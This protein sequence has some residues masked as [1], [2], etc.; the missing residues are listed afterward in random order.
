MVAGMYRVS[1]GDR[2]RTQRPRDAYRLEFVVRAAHDARSN[3]LFKHWRKTDSMLDALC[4]D[5]IYFIF[6]NDTCQSVISSQPL[7]VGNR[8]S[9]SANTEMQ[10]R[11][12]CSP[13]FE[14]TSPNAK[15]GAKESK[16]QKVPCSAGTVFVNTRYVCCDFELLLCLRDSAL[17]HG[18]WCAGGGGGEECNWSGVCWCAALVRLVRAPKIHE[19]APCGWRG[20]RQYL[21]VTESS[22]NGSRILQDCTRE[23]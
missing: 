5:E 12:R 2:G 15:A 7:R 3:A 17:E 18:L 8:P 19:H 6:Q 22:M 4:K 10:D 23:R 16:R 14:R 21:R 1:N 20:K 9:S 13:C 11:P